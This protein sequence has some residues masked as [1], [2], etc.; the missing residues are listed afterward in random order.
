M[1]EPVDAEQIRE[2]TERTYLEVAPILGVHVR[3][4]STAVVT[5]GICASLGIEAKLRYDRNYLSEKR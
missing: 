2:L 4:R 3:C 5:M 1:A